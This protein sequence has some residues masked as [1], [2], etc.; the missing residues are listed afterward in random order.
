MVKN[1]ERAIKL[2][3]QQH[4]YHIRSGFGKAVGQACSFDLHSTPSSTPCSTPS[5]TTT[6]TIG[7]FEDFFLT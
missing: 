6:S 4:R 3:A 5:S 1:N 7:F 2:A